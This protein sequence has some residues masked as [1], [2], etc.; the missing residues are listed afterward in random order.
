[1]HFNSFLYKHDVIATSI[2]HNEFLSNIVSIGGVQ[3][4]DSQTF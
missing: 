2:P 4:S 1:M 3:R